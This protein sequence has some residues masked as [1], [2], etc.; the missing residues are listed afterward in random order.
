MSD[1]RMI[2]IPSCVTCP[3]RQRHYGIDECS[4]MEFKELP[5]QEFSNGK[6]PNWCPLP[7]FKEE[8]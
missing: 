1:L 7:T 3:Y 4:K 2:L 6:I 5:K 8:V